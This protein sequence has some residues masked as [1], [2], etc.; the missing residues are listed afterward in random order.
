MRNLLPTALLLF[1][2]SVS[3]C[4][5]QSSFKPDQQFTN[6]LNYARARL[7][8]QQSKLTPAEINRLAETLARSNRLATII[9]EALFK[10]DFTNAAALLKEFPGKID[11]LNRYGQPLLYTAINENKSNVV[12]FLLEQKA[13]PDA[14]APYGEP[15]LMQAIQY[16][17]W[18]LAVKLVNAGASVTRTNNQGRTPAA[19]FFENWYPGS[20]GNDAATNFVPLMLEHGLDPFA[21]SRPGQPN[22]ILEECLNREGNYGG[23]TWSGRWGGPMAGTTPTMFGDLLLTNKPSPVRRTPLGDTALHLAAQ[24]QRTNAIEFLLAAGF[25]IDQTNDA[26]LTPLQSLVGNGAGGRY[27]NFG[28]SFSSIYIPSGPMRRGLSGQPTPPMTMTDYFLAKGAMLDIFSAAGLGKTNEVAALLATNATLANV[29]D[30]YGRTPLHYATLTAQPNLAGPVI[31]VSPQG[32]TT[33]VNAP[34]SSN[35]PPDVKSLLLK[36]GANPSAATTKAVPPLRYSSPLPAGTT[37]LHLAARNGN[38]PL[39]RTLLAARA[40]AKLADENGDTPLHAA[41]RTSQTNVLTLLLNARS[42][43]EATNRAGQTP[44]RAAVESSLDASAAYLLDAGASPTNGLGSNT[45]VHLA[46]ES[47]TPAMLT[48]LL[49]HKLKLEARDGEGRTPF[50]KAVM[51]KNWNSTTFLR[52]RGADLNAADND[53]NTALHLLSAQQDDNVSHPPE[54]PALVQWERKQLYTPGWTSTALGWL[55]KS[56][57]L[58]PPPAQGWTNTSL[59]SWLVEKGAKVNATNRAGQTPLHI[60]CGA[61]WQNWYDFHQ[62]SNRLTALFKAG[63][64]LD[65]PDTN[66]ATPLQIA[67]TNASP[68][69]LA[70]LVGKAGRSVNQPDAQGRTMLHAAVQNVGNDMQRVVALL[71]A[72]VDP[73]VADK[74]GRTPLHLVMQS[75][76][77]G[78]DWRRKDLVLTLLTNKAN[79]NLADNEGR[80]PLH[81][82]LQAYAENW[83]F[84]AREIV[85]LLLTNGANPN[86]VD[87][88]GRTPLHAMLSSTNPYAHRFNQMGEVLRDARW[89]FAARDRS[90]ETAIHLWAGTMENGWDDLESFKRILTNQNLVNLT[91]FAGDT[92]LHIAIRANKDHVARALMQINANPMLKNLKGETALR[93]AVEK[94]PAYYDQEVHPPGTQYRFFDSIRLRSEKD[95]NLWLEADPSL[96]VVTNASGATPLMAATDAGNTNIIARLLNLGAPMDSLSALRLGRVDEFRKLLPEVKRPVPGEWMFEA[97]RFGQLEALQILITAGGD[98]QFADADGNSLLLA[99]K[100]GKKTEI[101]EWL[102]AQG[103]RETLFDAILNADREQVASFIN[104]DA[105][106]VNSTNRNSRPPLYRAAVAGKLEVVTLLLEHGAKADAQIPGGWTALHVAAATDAVE[107]GKLLLKAGASPNAVAQGNMAPLHL[108]AA[109]GCTNMAELLLQNGADINLVLSQQGGYSR[110]TPLHW[111]AHIGKLDAFKLLLAHGADL[112]VLNQQN[113]TPLDLARATVRGQHWGFSRPPEVG[114]KNDQTMFRPATRDPMIKQ[115]EEAA[116]SK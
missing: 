71:A 98:V 101:A 48:M 60:L 19:M 66:G 34:A 91:N 58:N 13:S 87:R 62:S 44:L 14:A 21:P 94:S 38:T 61:E 112:N 89:D 102:A 24:Y 46:A 82:A 27:G 8:S 55:I 99:A 32:V 16:R 57:V 42:P 84:P 85:P 104:A 67:A 12:D 35:P 108:A 29:R 56:K 110:N 5:A 9:V 78:Y 59:S 65:L 31:R 53:G 26:G 70:F 109:L 80:T 105:G 43:L 63:A 7:N 97:V 72:G 15:V 54:E 52:D 37:P 76:N 22:S 50:Q 77:D 74:Q 11:S 18:D 49:A 25:S 20:S 96:A 10:G 39:V 92:P 51:S 45:L 68:S 47:G 83:N 79:P 73:N 100:L 2:I 6:E 103:C 90:G 30:A 33:V 81:L 17:R 93:L 106:C 3:K 116:A 95:F 115:L 107:I 41:A 36:A 64:R 40:D 88:A 1:V 69:I 4:V 113:Q 114:Y 111:A 28:S 75:R 23:G 86:A